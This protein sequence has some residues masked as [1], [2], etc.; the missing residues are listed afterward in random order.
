MDFGVFS[1]YHGSNGGRYY[2]SPK[3]PSREI[4]KNPLF[5][6]FAGESGFE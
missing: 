1:F 3:L 5:P 4:K 2:C 6:N